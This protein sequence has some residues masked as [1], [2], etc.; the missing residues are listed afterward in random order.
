[1]RSPIIELPWDRQLVR[2][3][4]DKV[5]RTKRDEW[6]KDRKDEYKTGEINE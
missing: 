4:R 3:Y 2:D 5:K 6:A 1:M